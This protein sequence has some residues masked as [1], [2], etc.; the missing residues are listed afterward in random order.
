MPEKQRFVGEL[1]RVAAP[2]EL[3]SNVGWAALVFR[4]R[5]GRGVTDR[6]LAMDL[7]SVTPY[8]KR[9]CAFLCMIHLV[10][11]WVWRPSQTSA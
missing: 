8:G 3:C 5:A 2:G 10:H 9:T 7:D 11:V 1:C 4:E 6:G